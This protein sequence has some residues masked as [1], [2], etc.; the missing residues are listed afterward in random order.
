MSVQKLVDE[1]AKNCAKQKSL[2]Q[3]HAELRDK[4]IPYLRKHNCPTSG[5]YLV[6]LIESERTK[7][8]W[9]ELAIKLMRKMGWDAAKRKAE[10]RKAKKL[11]GT[12]TVATLNP[13]VNP[14]WKE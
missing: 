1:F 10:I 9:E 11:A 13:K 8:S 12:Q 4:L 7:L 2:K 3:R 5:P 6:E 14:K